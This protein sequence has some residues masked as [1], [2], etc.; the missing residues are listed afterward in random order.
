MPN[1]PKN[2]FNIEPVD[3]EELRKSIARDLELPDR[4]LTISELAQL[5][6]IENAGTIKPAI[7]WSYVPQPDPE[8]ERLE[9]ERLIDEVDEELNEN[10]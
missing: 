5:R 9:E 6:A 7:D 4:P 2:I 3:T 1:K 8:R 10:T